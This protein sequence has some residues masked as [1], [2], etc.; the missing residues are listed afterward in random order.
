M[1]RLVI[2]S[3]E[4]LKAMLKGKEVKVT[5]NGT[6]TTYLSEDGYKAMLEEES[7]DTRK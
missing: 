2:F 7:K 1:R 6:T 4:E 5:Y 3:E